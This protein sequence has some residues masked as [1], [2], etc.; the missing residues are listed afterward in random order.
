MRTHR[1][2]SILFALLL[3][4]AC[5][6][7]DTT[8]PIE[9]TMG[10]DGEGTF[11]ITGASTG[12]ADTDAAGTID[13]E[14]AGI[15]DTEAT[16][17]QAIVEL[18]CDGLS[19]EQCQDVNDPNLPLDLRYLL[20]AA[21]P[22]EPVVTSIDKINTA[23]NNENIS[24]V[25]AHIY[26]LLS[27]FTPEKLQELRPEFVGDPGPPS[28]SITNM[29]LT[30]L[31]ANFASLDPE[32]QDVTRPFTLE[33]T[34]P[35]SYFNPDNHPSEAPSSETGSTQ[36]LMLAATQENPCGE[37]EVFKDYEG[38]WRYIETDGKLSNGNARAWIAAKPGKERGA[39]MIK[40]S[41]ESVWSAYRDLLNGSE[42]EDTITVWHTKRTN[43]GDS[44]YKNA[45]DCLVYIK[46]DMD[47]QMI[48]ATSSHELWHCFLYAYGIRPDVIWTHEASATYLGEDYAY[49]FNTEWKRL[50]QFYPYLNYP[51]FQY[52]NILEYGSYPLIKFLAQE[53]TL[54]SGG[55]NFIRSL[56][57]HIKV[58]SPGPGKVLEE[59]AFNTV[60]PDF[61]KLHRKY[62]LAS[63]N[64][65][66]GQI[67]RDKP[68][69]PQKYEK[70]PNG[71]CTPAYPA[72]IQY[73]ESSPSNTPKTYK[74]EMEKGGIVYHLFW[75][76]TDMTI[77]Y[78]QFQF[79]KL[80]DDS[81][82][83]LQALIMLDNGEW[84]A[85]EDWSRRENQQRFFCFNTPKESLSA[86]L[87]IGSNSSFEKKDLEYTLTTKENCVGQFKIT[88]HVVE[89]APVLYDPNG[90][91][92]TPRT[93]TTRDVT[94][95]SDVEYAFAIEFDSYVAVKS[96]T[97]FN[98]NEIAV[99]N[100][101]GGDKV[102]KQKCG[103]GE[104]TTKAPKSDTSAD[105]LFF[106]SPDETWGWMVPLRDG[107]MGEYQA[108][109][110]GDV[111]MADVLEIIQWVTYWKTSEKTDCDIIPQS[112]TWTGPPA[113][114]EY[115]AIDTS[116]FDV[117]DESST[118][119]HA[120]AEQSIEAAL[121]N[122][123]FT[124]DDF[125]DGRLKGQRRMDVTHTLDDGKTVRRNMVI[126]FDFAY[127]KE[128]VGRYE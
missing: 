109:D 31:H 73:K 65:G 104:K 52:G 28:D 120:I 83:R 99:E 126:E 92:N 46:D 23:L 34:H 69:F 43:Y 116:E 7:T 42:P 17:T 29:E 9:T 101:P 85:P 35:E 25:E 50:K 98:Y 68:Y 89:D 13:T 30:W 125:H 127:S 96:E 82:E 74:M 79:K 100:W 86:V 15:A 111:D 128:L 49:P 59:Y 72:L 10:E 95:I 11:D 21:V 38:G 124:K 66:P 47:G 14:A 39:C 112:N 51:I 5:T 64:M 37:S 103:Y 119:A 123:N 48:L 32:W 114:S 87:V 110:E 6:P 61:Y 40:K 45:K 41:M 115:V 102:I 84:L 18:P 70:C 53:Y 55:N 67:L 56:M 71:T 26:R 4:L 108:L 117:V 27:Q 121:S 2:Q 94:M 44:Y 16:A 57:D 107:S 1:L 54:P 60:F 78:A 62:A 88:S 106:I 19:E 105:L 91:I 90:D 20:L 3:G 80:F 8:G 122:I 118:D 36:A 22:T 63:A 12:T 93:I 76:P 75:F 97:E 113:A 81:K 24:E 33:P 77:Q 58:Q